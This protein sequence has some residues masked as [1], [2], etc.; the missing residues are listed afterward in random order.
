MQIIKLTKIKQWYLPVDADAYKTLRAIGVPL[1][2]IHENFLPTVNLLAKKHKT[3]FQALN[4]NETI[5]HPYLDELGARWQKKSN[6]KATITSNVL[7]FETSH[8]SAGEAAKAALPKLEASL[9]RFFTRWG[10]SATY[11]VSE[12]RGKIKFHVQY[13]YDVEKT[14]IVHL[15][16]DA[17]S[18]P[19]IHLDIGFV[20]LSLT[21]GEKE[22][23]TTVSVQGGTTWQPIH[24][25]RCLYSQV[26]DVRAMVNT[27][28][29]IPSRDVH[30]FDNKL[31]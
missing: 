21:L 26:S 3:R 20:R 17:T 8:Q 11:E 24:T 14:P 23:E 30:N 15:V 13:R 16:E 7:K 12:S 27:L 9:R 18:L 5:L 10:Y 1:I 25:S 22:I 2:R 4:F 31:K 6:R 29:D 28:M 19:Q